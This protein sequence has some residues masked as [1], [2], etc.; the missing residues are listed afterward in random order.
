LIYNLKE[1]LNLPLS[2][3]LNARN[4]LNYYYV[5][6]LGNLAP[7]RNISLQVEAKW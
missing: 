7:I 6:I 5:E 1:S 2:V 3:T 4:L